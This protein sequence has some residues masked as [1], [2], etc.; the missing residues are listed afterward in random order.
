MAQSPCKKQLTAL[1][2]NIHALE[3]NGSFDDCQALVKQAFSDESLNEKLLLTSANSINVARWLPQQIY[4][5]LALKQ[6]LKNNSENPVICVPSGN[7]GNIC[8]GIL[9]HHRG[10]PVEH[11]IAACNVND[12]VPEY[13]RTEILQPK[14]T[15]ATISN[16]M[17]VGDPSNFVRILELFDKEFNQVKNKLSGYTIDD[18]ETLKTI[19][20]VEKDYGYV[21]DPHGAV[22]FVALEKYLAENGG[23]GFFLE[24]AHPVKFPDSVEKATGK[25]VEIPKS[26]EELMRQEKFTTEINPQYEELKGF[27]LG[28]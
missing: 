11:F 19:E 24:T 6:W 21:L 16:A 25:S 7:F 20:R 1:G 5:V 3:V 8:A 10:L 9:A 26:L 15:V 2:K 17:D 28:K 22:A 18:G 27:L 23:K 14:E 12:V 4:Y 13:L